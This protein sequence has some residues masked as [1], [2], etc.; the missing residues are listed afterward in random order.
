MRILLSFFCCSLAALPQ[1]VTLGVIGGVSLT[2]ST[3][4][5]RYPMSGVPFI[6]TSPGSRS[7]LVGPTFDVNFHRSFA[8][9][10]DALYRP[11][12]TRT[13]T[14]LA[15]GTRE[16]AVTSSGM[17]WQFP[18]L[19]KYRFEGRGIVRPFL[20]AGP[21]FRV[22]EQSTAEHSQYGVTAGAGADIELSFLRVSPTVRYTRWAGGQSSFAPFKQ[23]QVEILVAFGRALPAAGVRPFGRRLSFGLLLGASFSDDQRTTA[24]VFNDPR[25]NSPIAVARTAG[26]RSVLP[27]I[28]VEAELARGFSVEGNA[29]YRPYRQRVVTAS[30]SFGGNT[31]FRVA[32]T[33]EFPVLA[34]YRFG[35]GGFRPFLEGGPSFRTAD[36]VAGGRL[37]RVGVTGGAGVEMRLG[38]L[39]IAPR[40]RYTHWSG[41]SL[42]RSPALRNQVQGLVGFTF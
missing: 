22:S 31:S 4:R 40:V 11:L 9:E 16:P 15:D 34:K 21:S 26:P 19:L 13:R 28:A 35:N 5:A 23:D 1:T 3:G 36:W 27:G 6:E 30:R 41:E 7:F 24:D 14:I 39:R 18:V 42:G 32:D 33:F 17:T 12:E 2:E 37:G 10:I 25:D 20:A 8:L 29:I 38:H